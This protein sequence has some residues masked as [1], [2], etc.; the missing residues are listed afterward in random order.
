[1]TYSNTIPAIQA[2][3]GMSYITAKN[4]T[5]YMSGRVA[6]NTIEYVQGG[7]VFDT[8]YNIY[9]TDGYEILVD[10]VTADEIM[11]YNLNECTESIVSIL[12]QDVYKWSQHQDR[13]SDF[14]KTA[15]LEV[16]RTYIN[17]FG[18]FIEIYRETDF[19]FLGKGTVTGRTSRCLIFNKNGTTHDIHTSM[20]D[21]S[22]IVD[23]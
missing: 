22:Y 9:D 6:E 1:M 23:L 11:S 2:K 19:F 4:N 17:G 12:M 18:E 15:S 3:S 10:P 5:I 16:G 14:D 8:N 21:L 7:R 13:I 20:S